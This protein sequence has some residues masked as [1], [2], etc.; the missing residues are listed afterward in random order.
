MSYSTLREL[1][2][3]KLSE[4]G[5]PSEEF[6]LHS[7][8][9]GG[10]SAAANAGVPDRLFKKHG[11]RKSENAKDGYIEDSLDSRLSVSRQMGL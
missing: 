3:K 7:L 5:Y 11:R 6:G 8:R 4:L 2:K 1:F 10:A 9:A